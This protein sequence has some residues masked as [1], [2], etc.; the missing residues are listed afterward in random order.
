MKCLKKGDINRF[1]QKIPHKALFASRVSVPPTVVWVIQLR[2]RSL[3]RTYAPKRWQHV[4]PINSYDCQPWPL[5][6]FLW[7]CNWRWN[8]YYSRNTKRQVKFW[9]VEHY[10]PIYVKDI[11]S[12]MYV[13]L[14]H[15]SY[16]YC[17]VYISTQSKKCALVGIVSSWRRLC[18]S[19][20]SSWVIWKSL[21]ISLQWWF[22]ERN[23]LS[24]SG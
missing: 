10:L 20:C 19:V 5:R 18:S 23:L 6:V 4:E 11:Q 15:I 3:F 8:D 7:R 2:T 22:K 13:V 21:S 1:K 12:I 17:A 9:T 24:A 16:M 14:C